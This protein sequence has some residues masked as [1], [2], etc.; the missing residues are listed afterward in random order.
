[1]LQSVD[2][3]NPSYSGLWT[4]EIHSFRRHLLFEPHFILNSA[5]LDHTVLSALV[6]ST[7][8]TTSPLSIGIYPNTGTLEANSTAHSL[9]HTQAWPDNICIQ[10]LKEGTVFAWSFA[11]YAICLIISHDCSAEIGAWQP[12]E[13]CSDCSHRLSHTWGGGT[14][15]STAQQQQSFK[16]DWETPIWLISKMN[17]PNWHHQ[18]KNT[19]GFIE[20]GIRVPMD[21]TGVLRWWSFKVTIYH[22]HVL[23]QMV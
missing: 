16:S 10:D 14:I 4:W 1:M 5:T 22:H 18:Y 21:V 8:L 12:S 7:N 13:N 3:D 9:P 20:G 23:C 17:K 19:V 11:L 15:G 6:L 2:A